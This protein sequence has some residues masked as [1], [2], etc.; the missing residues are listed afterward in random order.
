MDRILKQ[1]QNI[2]TT[3]VQGPRGIKTIYYGDPLMIPRADFPAIVIVPVQTTIKY[4]TNVQ[5]IDTVTINVFLCGDERQYVGK[6]FK[7]VT[8][9]YELGKIMEE[10][11]SGTSHNLKSD[12]I[13]GAIRKYFYNDSDFLL[14]TDN[15]KIQYDFD[16]DSGFSKYL[17]V[18]TFDVLTKNYLR[19]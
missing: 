5:D 16:P 8:A 14:K 1:I 11:E 19:V 18:L 6:D 4:D 7:E 15:F 12:T 13:A 10:R 17:V 2:L 3:Y 9:L